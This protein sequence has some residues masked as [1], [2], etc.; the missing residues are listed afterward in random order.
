MCDQH[1]WIDAVAPKNG[2]QP[3]VFLVEEREEEI[4]RTD[5]RATS[6]GGVMERKL[7]GD[8][9]GRRDDHSSPTVARPR[10]YGVLEGPQDRP[11]IQIELPHD[12]GKAIPL[13]FGKREREVL[14]AQ[15]RMLAP[16]RVVN[17]PIHDPPRR[18]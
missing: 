11:G 14:R 5:A 7:Q 13:Y 4:D 8:F 1:P 10:S 17:R 18:V 3:A 12:L 16:A 6:A 2:R 15:P 9:R